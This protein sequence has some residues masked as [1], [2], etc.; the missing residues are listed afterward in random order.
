MT[1][2]KK[3][4]E[5]KY[6]KRPENIRCKCSNNEG[7]TEALDY[8]VYSKVLNKPFDSLAE[9]R[10]AEAAYR[11]EQRAKEARVATKKADA[12]KVE[13][14]FKVMNQARKDYKENLVKL[15]E[16]YQEDLKKLKA[17]FE[18]DRARVQTA[19]ADAEAGYSAALKE[20]TDKY[21]EGYHI[22]LKDGDF[23][24]TISGHNQTRTTDVS[25]DVMDIL[26]M[27]FKI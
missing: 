3:N 8:A 5:D 14:A 10:E 12:A 1:N 6:F 11:A 21:P 24:T 22:T 15:T 23:E 7:H 4:K 26:K 16:M 18:A 27:L 25:Q 9:L 17:A 2:E 20:F 19:L 13:N